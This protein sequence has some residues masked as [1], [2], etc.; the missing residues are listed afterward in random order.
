MSDQEIPGESRSSGIM[1]AVGVGA[2]IA[3]LGANVYLYLQ[4]DQTRNDV[5]K[6]RESVLSELQNIREASTVTTATARRSIDTLK[7]ELENAR[8]QASSAA[9]IAKTEA[10][11]HA[12]KL[13]KQLAEE[14]RRQAQQVAGQISEVK[15]VAST[16]TAKIGEV[17]TEVT[18]V[19][20]EVTST[21]AELEKTISDL[22]RVT[23]D[24]GVQSGLI[25][26]NGKE[27]AA[28]RRL[29]ERDYF[30]FKLGK[31]KDP[32]RVGNVTL[33]LKRTDPKKNKYTVEVFADDKRTEKK[34]KSINEPVQFIVSKARQPYELVVNEVKKDL[35]VGYLSVPKDQVSR[36]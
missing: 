26:T 32:Q 33:L 23:G 2:V 18:A 16:A 20:G 9:G 25:A 3:L 24:L 31:A 22:K 17:G 7:T 8:R 14:Q 30:E 1:T 15:E 35:I 11:A 28:L 10:E 19:K 4:L 29:G 5:N 27:L 36:N 21:K 34:D 6:L 12:D 13:A